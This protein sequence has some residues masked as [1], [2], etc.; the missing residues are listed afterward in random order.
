MAKSPEPPKMK[1]RQQFV[2]TFKMTRRGDPQLLWWLL[3]AFLV[4]AAVGFALFWFLPGSGTL[5]LVSAVIGALM[6]GLLAALVIFSRRG[7]ASGDAPL[8]RPPGAAAAGP[9]A[10]RRGREAGA[11]GGLHKQPRGRA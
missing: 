9:T 10:L 6:V 4:G 5:A 3:G 11:G 2:E 8:H 7:Q 1:R